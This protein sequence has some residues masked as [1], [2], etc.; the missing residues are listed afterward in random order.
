MKVNNIY[1]GDCLELMKDIPGGSVD[2]VLAD[3]PYGTTQNK[4]DC[5]L[6]LASLWIM[7]RVILRKNGCIVLFGNQPFTSDLV[8]SN[9]RQI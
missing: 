7:Y 4:W 5:I 3:L 8:L 2:M 9:K 6:P 1:H